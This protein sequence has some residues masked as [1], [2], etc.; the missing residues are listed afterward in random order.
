MEDIII[1]QVSGRRELKEF[2][3][4]PQILHKN[5]LNWVPPLYSE[6]KRYFDQS[7]NH[8]FKYC[9][10]VEVLARINGQVAG[11]IMGIINHRYNEARNESIARFSQFDCVNDSKVS[12]KLLDFVEKWA[13]ERGMDKI[14]GPMGMYYHNPIGFLI[15]GF[16]EKPSFDANFNFDYIIPLVESAGYCSEADLVVYQVRIPKEFPDYYLQIKERA[17]R[18]SKL[19]IAGIASRKQIRQYISPVLNLMNETYKDILGYSQLDEEEMQEIASQFIPLLDP[20]FLVIATYKNEI[21]GFII[22]IPSL[23]DGLIAAKGRLFP[24]GFL[25]IM[26]AAKRT[27]QLD[28]LLGAI[29]PGFQGKGIDAVMGVHLMETARKLGFQ[30]L[31]SHL[32]LESNLKVRAE[33]EKMGGTI[34]KKYRIYKKELNKF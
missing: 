12:S 9:S 11:R 3:Y 1:Q 16:N 28:L 5:H 2:I 21:V 26:K 15:E 27:T 18:N 23:N 22:A 17:L 30:T 7:K 32:E 6:E 4:F 24:F 13:V 34:L 31:D 29:K 25:K 14:I 8:G 10:T 20:R 19:R 33:M